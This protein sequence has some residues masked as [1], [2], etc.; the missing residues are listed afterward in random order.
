MSEEI[1]IFLL[2]CWLRAFGP[3]FPVLAGLQSNRNSVG[4]LRDLIGQLNWISS[5][6]I[7]TRTKFH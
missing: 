6:L 7:V 4:Y 1:R 3:L 2:A 5:G